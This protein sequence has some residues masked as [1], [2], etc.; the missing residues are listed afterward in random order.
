MSSI[1]GVILAAGA[2]TRLG[3]PKQLLD[4]Q[5]CSLIRRVATTAI[6]S[7]AEPVIVVLG[8]NAVQIQP[9]LR[10]L[11]TQVVIN[12][13]WMD[14]IS[15]SIHIGIE[16]LL[17]VKP[18]VEAAV[19]L[20]CDQPFISPTLINQLITTYQQAHPRIIASA[21]AGVVGVP[22]LF[23]HTLFPALMS[24]SGDRGAK[25]I[26]QQYSQFTQTIPYP[27]AAFDIDTFADY[28]QL[29]HTTLHH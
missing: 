11:E 23:D 8:A 26:M 2:S 16:A 24:L 21:Y 10:D 4:Y 20:V 13:Q 29:L 3:T 28:T 9:E 17:A 25:Q 19:L 27:E 14:G 5:G 1:G 12:P 7:L 18:D 22:A 6:A 15:T